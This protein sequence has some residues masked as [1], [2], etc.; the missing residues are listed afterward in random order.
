MI[1]TNYKLTNKKIPMAKL[2]DKIETY[3]L[4][5]FLSLTSSKDYEDSPENEEKD[6]QTLLKEIEKYSSQGIEK[7]PAFENVYFIF[8]RLKSTII[9]DL[10]DRI[11]TEEFIYE[12]INVKGLN[13]IDDLNAI[14]SFASKSYFQ[15][16][17]DLLTKEIY[18]WRE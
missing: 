12:F 7:S 13:S 18:E 9:N 14:Q 1:M 8:N 5:D 17:L 15:N 4:A 2:L 10:E 16:Q 6:R 3:N 11:G